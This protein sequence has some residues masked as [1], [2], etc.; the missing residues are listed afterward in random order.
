MTRL[1]NFLAFAESHNIT[2]SCAAATMIAAIAY[3]DWL[4]P[5]TSVGYLYLIPILLSSAGLNWFEILLMALVCGWLRE[6][7]DPLQ[8]AVGDRSA[9]VLNPAR[10]VAGSWPRFIVAASGFKMCIR[11]RY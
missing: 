3:A 1:D 4:V 5:N 9:F 7:A 11:D 2:V 6:A 10:W 8:G